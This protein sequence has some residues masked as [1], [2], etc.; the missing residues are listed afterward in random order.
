ME[1]HRV[2]PLLEVVMYVG[3]ATGLAAFKELPVC[4]FPAILA[5]RVPMIDRYICCPIA[6]KPS[7]KFR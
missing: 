5:D 4:P 1:K 3:T 2:F 6:K 7:D